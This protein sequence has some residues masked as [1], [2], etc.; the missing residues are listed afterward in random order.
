MPRHFSNS[1][2]SLSFSLRFVRERGLLTSQQ[3]GHPGS[4]L[5]LNWLRGD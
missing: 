3:G 2:I 4:L 1:L 5:G